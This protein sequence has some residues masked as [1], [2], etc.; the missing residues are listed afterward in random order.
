MFPFTAECS[1]IILP[2][3]ADDKQKALAFLKGYVENCK[4]KDVLIWGN[5]MSFKMNILQPR[6]NKFAG[7]NKGVFTLLDTKLVFKYQ[8]Y[9]LL[10]ALFIAGVLIVIS[11]RYV[12]MLVISAVV[13]FGNWGMVFFRFRR[14]T[15]E[16]AQQINAL[17]SATI[18]PKIEHP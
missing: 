12:D 4:A 16:L 11:P 15:N 1:S 7:I 8:M 3:N 14:M 9:S 5:E 17:R 18:L 10:I 2:L 13:I 6:S